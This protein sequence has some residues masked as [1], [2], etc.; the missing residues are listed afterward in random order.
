MIA[1]KLVAMYLQFTHKKV[2]VP[3]LLIESDR[4]TGPGTSRQPAEKQ[5]AKSSGISMIPED[6]EGWSNPLPTPE[7]DFH[8]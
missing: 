3:A 4:G 7:G 2:N 6:K 8:F 1:V 5:G